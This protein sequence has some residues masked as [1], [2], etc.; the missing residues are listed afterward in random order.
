[1]PSVQQEF[2]Y[3]GNEN[4]P[5]PRRR[6]G[7]CLGKKGGKLGDYSSKMKI[8]EETLLFFRSPPA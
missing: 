5:P 3:M 4:G 8:T 7:G 1:M 6:Q 2:Q